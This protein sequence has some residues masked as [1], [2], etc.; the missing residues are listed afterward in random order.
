MNIIK[1]RYVYFFI[2]LVNDDNLASGFK[3]VRAWAV[4]WL[5]IELGQPPVK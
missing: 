5:V 4:Y 3:A 2:S 1:N